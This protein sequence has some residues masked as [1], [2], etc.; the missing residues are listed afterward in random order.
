MS[1][2]DNTN[3]GA[4]F[5]NDKQGN[6]KWPD[7]TGSLNVNGEEFWISA[8]LRESKKGQKYMS[9][10]VESKTEPSQNRSDES[11]SGDDLPED[12]PF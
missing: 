1:D 2:F 9:L 7:Y 3:R 5:R 8:W 11:Q 12:L 10:S 4:L 6:E